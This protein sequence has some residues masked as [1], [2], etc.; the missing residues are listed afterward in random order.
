MPPS[1]PRRI[2]AVE[3]PCRPGAS[4]TARGTVQTV[5]TD[6]AVAQGSKGPK[7]ADAREHKR[8]LWAD[9]HPLPPWEFRRQKRNSSA[10]H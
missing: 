3:P 2:R 1:S 4:D 6:G 10:A 9:P 7:F 5:S 8:G